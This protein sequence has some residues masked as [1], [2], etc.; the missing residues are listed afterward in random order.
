MKVSAW[1]YQGIW[2]S[3]TG[4]ALRVMIKSK[5]PQIIFLFEMKCSGKDFLHKAR[6]HKGWNIK[7]V[8]VVGLSGGL[9]ILWRKDVEVRVTD[10]NDRYLVV[11]IIEFDS[12]LI[13]RTIFYLW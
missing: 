8:D 12:N 9:V 10:M 13:W 7:V 11:H 1:N 4:R 6:I 2:K 5:N 3:L